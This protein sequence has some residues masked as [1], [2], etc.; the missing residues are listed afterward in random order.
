MN[1]SA[2]ANNIP[3]ARQQQPLARHAIVIG[4]SMAGLLAARVLSEYF[5]RV[6][7]VERDRPGTNALPRP[8]VPQGR[9]L[10]V[11]LSA[12]EQIL[13]QLFP[14]LPTELRQAGAASLDFPGDVLWFQGGGYKTRFCS[15]IA[16]LL[17]SRPLLEMQVRR[18]VL[19]LANVAYL[20]GSEVRG[21][22]ASADGTSVVG[23]KVQQRVEGASP[24]TLAA[25]L[26]V[27]A[28]GRGSRS[29]QWLAALGY[30]QPRETAIQVDVRYATR[31]FQQQPAALPHAR[32]IFIGPAPPAG[33]RAG[34]LVP[35]EGDRWAVTLVG[36]LGDCP[37]ADAD[38]FLEYA[39]SLPAPDLHDALRTATP[40]T[41][42]A[43]HALP[44]SL[45]R[46]YE[47]SS[48]FPEGFLVLGDAFCSF[49]PFYGQGMSVS[50]LEAGELARCL[51]EA[52]ERQSL[53]GLARTFFS[54]AARTVATPW[55][56]AAVEDFR[57]PEVEGI[58]PLGTR[59][60]AQYLAL[61]NQASFSDREVTRTFFRVM[62]LTQPPR[63]LFGPR[64]VLG[65]LRALGNG[66]LQS[67]RRSI[68][69]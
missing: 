33:K 20:D 7:L 10:H 58:K 29:P 54:R 22:V 43:T 51:Q 60:I 64:V 27:D 26:V 61:L 31:I 25:D 45:R 48:H 6:T 13:T 1:D 5:E 21:L 15:G 66:L 69:V 17:L 57:F 23:V 55:T 9:H 56:M 36:W 38:G 62:T 2:I 49:N 16:L 8:G 39:K 68:R 42:I 35:I 59:A 52:R 24:A 34:A 37:P 53:Q 32:G 3:C 63:T 40:L 28:T 46:H 44:S 14:G 18:R 65:A 12:G 47:E 50:A 11:L 19:E 41:D 4:A 30:P 67:P